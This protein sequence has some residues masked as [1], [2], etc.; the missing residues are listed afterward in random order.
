MLLALRFVGAISA[1]TNDWPF[2]QQSPASAA[3]IVTPGSALSNPTPPPLGAPMRQATWEKLSYREIT[4][5]GARALALNPRAWFHGETED[6][7]IHYRNFSDALQVAR[8]IEFDLWYVAKS[9][10]ATRE[11][12][13]RKSHVYIFQDEKEWQMFLPEARQPAWVH[14]FAVH[15]D[16]FLNIHGTGSG[17]DSRTL[18]H[19]TTH[20]VVSRIYGKQRWP[21]WLSEGFA[22]YMG[23]ASNAAR[24]GQSP[25]SNPSNRPAATM[26]VTELIAVSRYPEDTLTVAELYD[27]GGKFVRYLFSKYPAE[28]FPKFVGRLLDGEPASAVLAEIYGNEFRDLPAFDQRFQTTIR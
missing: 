20:A 24:R 2:P 23:D 17:F 21:I 8:E 22:E 4:E 9:L 13:A 27:T 1:A 12:Y 5:I 26:T 25:G 19:E 18:A 14:S 3:R 28:L 7:V 10:G 6:F 11:Q 15:D 16:L